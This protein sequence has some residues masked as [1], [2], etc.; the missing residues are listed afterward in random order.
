MI[1]L[2]ATPPANTPPTAQNLS[3]VASRNGSAQLQLAAS[4]PDS[5]AL[6]FAIVT[7][8]QHGTLTLIS[9]LG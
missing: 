3:A 2:T 5:P 9:P 7:P 1:T 6:S 8:P 4:D